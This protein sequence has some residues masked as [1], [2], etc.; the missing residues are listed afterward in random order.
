MNWLIK[1]LKR[2][3]DRNYSGFWVRSYG[4]ISIVICFIYVMDVTHQIIH[5]GFNWYS[6]MGITIADGITFI[7]LWGTISLILKYKVLERVEF[8]ID[9]HR[10]NHE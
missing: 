5:S 7:L 8:F 4:V 9:S 1:E 10:R 6:L 2:I 3:N